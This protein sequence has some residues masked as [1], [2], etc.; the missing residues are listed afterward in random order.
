MSIMGIKRKLREI[1]KQL[2][3]SL[4]VEIIAIVIFVLVVA[5]KSGERIEGVFVG[6][7][8]GEGVLGNLETYM[9][10]NFP[11]GSGGNETDG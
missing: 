1:R 10:S 9:K 2:G 6:G 3:F 7:G 8:K 5:S 11:D 4:T